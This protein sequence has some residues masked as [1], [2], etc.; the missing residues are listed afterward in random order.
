MDDALIGIYCMI[1]DILKALQHKEKNQRKMSDAEVLFTAITAMDLFGGNYERAR[2]YLL[3]HHYIPNAL[4]KSR[5]N[6]RLHAIKDLL[7]PI[8]GVLGGIWKELS[9]T[10]VYIIDSFPIAVCDNIR[11][12]R[13]RIY[14]EEEYRGYTSSKKRYFYGLKIHLMITADGKPVE[15]FL[16]PGS[17]A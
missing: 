8:F 13:C 11:I 4:G 1:D 16:T 17:F 6:R 15:F 7:Q 10:S 3:A 5:L 14:Q 12:P 2:K 9:S